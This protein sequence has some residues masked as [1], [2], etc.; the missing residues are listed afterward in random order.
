MDESE[1]YCGADIIADSKADSHIM[2]GAGGA[3]YPPTGA[4]VFPYTSFNTCARPA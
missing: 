1:R 3:L 4:T 2:R